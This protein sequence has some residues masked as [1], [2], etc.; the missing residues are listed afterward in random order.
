[1][2]TWSGLRVDALETNCLT[3]IACIV[4]VLV[5]ISA[6]LIV[7]LGSLGFQG[8]CCVIG[9]IICHRYS[10]CWRVKVAEVS[11]PNM[12]LQHMDIET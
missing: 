1:M 3:R 8:M 5:L 9:K 10:G 6:W 11:F 2:G 12:Y 4:D 7:A